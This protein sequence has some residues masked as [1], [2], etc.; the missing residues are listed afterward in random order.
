VSG[1]RAGELRERIA[2]EF[3]ELV[4]DGYGNTVSGDWTTGPTV[5]ARIQPLRGAETVQAARLAGK[6]PVEI[7]I[8]RSAATVAVTTDWRARDVRTGTVYNV[9]SVVNPD[10]KHRF[11][12][13]ECELGVAT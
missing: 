9:R 2:F 11:L 3:Q 1:T 10:E 8:R 13:L 5:A 12:A 6:Q 4:D 7:T